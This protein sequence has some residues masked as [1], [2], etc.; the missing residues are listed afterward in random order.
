MPMTR[1]HSVQHHA[2]F[3]AD[4]RD[5]TQ[6]IR[7]TLSEALTAVGADLT[8]PQQMARQLGLD[9]SLS[10]KVTKIL[11]DADPVA[12]IPRL[13]GRSGQK[14]IVDALL[15]AGAP[16]EQAEAVR[17]AMDE[18]ERLVS[19]HAG[20]RDTLEIML[21]SLTREGQAD[22]DEA[23]RRLAYQA[24]SATWG[25]RA[26]VQISAHFAAPSTHN[27]GMLDL[28]IASGLVDFRRLR[29]DA[30]WAVATIR[31]ITDDGSPRGMVNFGPLDPA[32]S[33]P[34]APPL[35]TAF[36]SNPL[37][38]IRTAP[39]RNGAVRCEIAEGPV[40]NTGAATC[41]TGWFTRAA[42][43]RWRSPNDRYGEHFVSMTTPVETI[44][45]DLFVHRSMT[46]ALDPTIH[47]YSQLPGG[48]VYPA[49]GRTQGLL[50]I[51]DP[52]VR[53]G[54]PPD[55]TTPDYAPFP[56]L[57]ESVMKRMEWNI[58]DFVGFRFRLRYPP[59]PALAVLRY[60]LPERA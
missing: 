60:E 54:G 37:P 17:A 38:A 58:A 52:V 19:V 11:S 44:F 56:R 32:I 33:D 29:Q 59:I 7:R 5:A 55:L 27:A 28:A 4:V 15:K 12:A 36:S 2:T 22:R 6:A 13:P 46:F 10:W 14:I 47:V 53:L 50:P 34:A 42:V 39:T 30:A 21:S 9:K 48:P 1:S 43:S 31:G 23:Q 16:S 20:D 57:V 18:F 24:N 35:M 26:R 8:R 40:G 51:A 45:H 41:M 49:D 25:V 3:E